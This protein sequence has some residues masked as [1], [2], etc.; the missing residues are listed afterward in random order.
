MNICL[1]VCVFKRKVHAFVCMVS[2][3]MH[4]QYVFITVILYIATVILCNFKYC[5]F[6]Y[7]TIPALM[8]HSAINGY[9]CK[10]SLFLDKKILPRGVNCHKLYCHFLGSDFLLWMVNVHTTDIVQVQH[11]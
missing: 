2:G 4:M 10:N 9:I 5:I 8:G 11:M 3:Y 7:F 6:I 1:C